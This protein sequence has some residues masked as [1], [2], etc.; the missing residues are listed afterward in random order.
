MAEVDLWPLTEASSRVWLW[1][2]AIHLHHSKHTNGISPI[3]PSALLFFSSGYDVI[4]VWGWKYSRQVKIAKFSPSR[5][6]MHKLF[7]CY[8]T[9][10]LVNGGERSSLGKLNNFECSLV[11]LENKIVFRLSCHTR[12]ALHF[13]FFLF[14]EGWLWP[15]PPACPWLKFGEMLRGGCQL[16]YQSNAPL[17]GPRFVVTPCWNGGSLKPNKVLL[18]GGWQQWGQM[19]WLRRSC[20]RITHLY[21]HLSRGTEIEWKRQQEKCSLAVYCE[22]L[23]CFLVPCTPDKLRY[24]PWWLTY[25]PDRWDWILTSWCTLLMCTWV[26]LFS[27]RWFAM[28]SFSCFLYT[29]Q[30]IY[31]RFVTFLSL[32]IRQLVICVEIDIGK[33]SNPHKTIRIIK[34]DKKLKIHF[35]K[36]RK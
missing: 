7:W 11:L 28:L 30:D 19:T 3:W 6:P 23:F 26:Q 1:K 4:A 17:S 12:D 25:G 21:I 24:G 9:E 36:M 13:L 31:L 29:L 15:P 8:T 18:G 34:L 14:F 16:W 5:Q 2:S 27:V 32:T 22:Y 10:R 33:E 20:R 35:S